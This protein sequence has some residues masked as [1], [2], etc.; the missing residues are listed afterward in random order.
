MSQPGSPIRRIVT[1]HDAT[2]KAVVLVDGDAPNVRL[3]K[4]TGITSTLLWTTGSVPAT[5]SN[6]DLGAVQ[7]ATAPPPGTT[8]LRV[9]EFP[10][11]DPNAAPTRKRP[12]GSFAAFGYFNFF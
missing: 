7:I 4:E 9:V 3:R 6:D 5:F 12:C 8:L 2:G 1:T 10:P 11:E